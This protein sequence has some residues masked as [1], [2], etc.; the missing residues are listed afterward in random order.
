[1]LSN[2]EY[3]LNFLVDA[4]VQ[5]TLSTIVEIVLWTSIFAGAGLSAIGGFGKEYYIAYALCATFLSR[6]S[7]S[8]MYEFRMIQEIESGTINSLIVRPMSFYEYY[9][10]QLLGYK[11]ITTVI[12]L[13]I[14]LS[15]FLVYKLPFHWD[16]LPISLL[17]VFYYLILVHSMSFVVSCF[18]FFLNRIQGITSAKNLGLWLLSGEL[19]PL[20]LLPEP[21]KTIMIQLPFANAVYVPTGYITGRIGFEYIK[22]GFVSITVGI[23]VVNLIGYFF[24]RRGLKAYVGTGA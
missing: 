24:W 17:M 11:F 15:V 22:S 3:R 8:W 20:D 14:P 13:T 19:F 18:A 5:P 1:M 21:L 10:S 16:R 6:I 23:I 4:I 2:L 9:L 12:S 7:S